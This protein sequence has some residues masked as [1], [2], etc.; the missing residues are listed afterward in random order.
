MKILFEIFHTQNGLIIY[1]NL[2]SSRKKEESMERKM[3]SFIV[4]IF[5]TDISSH[6]VDLLK[7]HHQYPVK[8]RF[9]NFEIS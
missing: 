9:W 2:G 6:D 7:K 1:F 8:I 4:K 5:T 3:M